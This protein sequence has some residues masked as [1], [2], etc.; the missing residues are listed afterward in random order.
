MPPPKHRMLMIMALSEVVL[1]EVE[2]SRQRSSLL[3][4]R[5]FEALN[6][7]DSPNVLSQLRIGDVG[8]RHVEVALV[9][10]TFAPRIPHNEALLEVVIAH[11]G[12]GVAA[13]HLVPWLRH[14]HVPRLGHVAGEAG[15][16]SEAEN[17]GIAVLDASLQ[18]IQLLRDLG[19]AHDFALLGQVVATL[20]GL[21]LEEVMLVVVLPLFLGA[22]AQ[23]LHNFDA[24]TDHGACVPVHTALH[25]PFVVVDEETAGRE[26]CEV[27][28]ILH[29]L[30]VQGEVKGGGQGIGRAASQVSLIEDGEATILRTQIHELLASFRLLLDLAGG[31]LLLKGHMQIAMVWDVWNPAEL[32]GAWHVIPLEMWMRVPVLNQLWLVG[33]SAL[34]SAHGLK[35]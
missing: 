27:C 12:H 29:H 2:A 32:L 34:A 24:I 31:L 35:S 6:P 15:Q 20:V 14:D 9:T 28:I 17:E 8:I 10:P 4:L 33:G 1:T 7:V 18:L 11:S 25:I 30:L 5:V 23:L 16:H 19:V 3:G 21:L 13:T 26:I 22:N